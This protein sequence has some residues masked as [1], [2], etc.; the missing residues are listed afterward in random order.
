LKK[1]EIY[2]VFE[3]LTFD[4]F[5]SLATN[6]EL[7]LNEK[8]GFPDSYREG[9][10]EFI[11]EDI[12]SKLNILNHKNKVVLD[13]GTGCGELA[14]KLIEVCETNEHHLVLIDSK[15]MLDYLPEFDF[16]KKIPACYPGECRDFINEYKEKVDVILLYSVI[17]YIFAEGNF[18]DFLDNTMSLLKTGGQLLLGD[19]P[20]ISM[21]K[22]FLS[23][24]RGREFH[25]NFYGS[26]SEPEVNFHKIE[27][28]Q[29]DDSIVISIIM[30]A[31]L[32]GYHAYLLPQASNLPM[33]NRRED[34]LIIKP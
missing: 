26:D 30:R 21:R 2:S 34:I 3:N 27:Y 20:N 7:S 25:K 24:Q 18:Y 31:R 11:F 33:E 28:A 5:R 13:I 8:V 12:K 10:N 1:N 4:G 16:I 14:T 6:S 22:R 29:I 15:E 19:I 32:A 17:Q 9:K 23:S